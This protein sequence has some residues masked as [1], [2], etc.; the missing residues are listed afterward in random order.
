MRD[1][2]NNFNM[3][4]NKMKRYYIKEYFTKQTLQTITKPTIFR[5]S[6]RFTS[7]YKYDHYR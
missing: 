3:F 7:R 1:I 2:K 4:Y 5:T 6:T